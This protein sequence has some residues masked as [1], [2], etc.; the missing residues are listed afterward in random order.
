MTDWLVL[1]RG[2][3][4][5]PAA[6]WYGAM[7]VTRTWY[8]DLP[9][10]TPNGD[11]E[12]SQKYQSGFST[13][14]V[15]RMTSSSGCS[16]FLCSSVARKEEHVDASS[17]IFICLTLDGVEQYHMQP[18]RQLLLEVAE[19]ELIIGQRTDH[20]VRVSPMVSEVGPIG[21][22][23]EYLR[24]ARRQSVSHV[25]NGCQLECR[26]R[27]CLERCVH[28]K[29]NCPRSAPGFCILHRR[30]AQKVYVHRSSQAQANCRVFPREARPGSWSTQ[31]RNRRPGPTAD[32]DG[33]AVP[34]PMR[35]CSSAMI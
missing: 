12:S 35:S 29:R 3:A 7:V 24:G 32:R 9:T 16:I 23:E 18:A 6:C 13:H 11:F 5:A 20:T 34:R 28:C 10:E 22:C 4:A 8:K 25:A 31:C 1:V 19:E 33:V 27:A 14:N 21:Q 26:P 15:I 30:S 2:C 17:A